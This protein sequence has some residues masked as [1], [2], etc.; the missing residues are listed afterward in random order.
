[1]RRRRGWIFTETI[2]A[3]GLI[4]AIG[5]MMAISS[6]RYHRSQQRLSDQQ[7]ATHRAEAAL[8][9]WQTNEPLPPETRIDIISRNASP[10]RWAKATAQYNGQTAEL[11]GAAEAAHAAGPES[12]GEK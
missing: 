11:Y 5:S 8:A 4:T 12:A 6:A 10:L 7:I 3:I 2:V 9:A 1:M